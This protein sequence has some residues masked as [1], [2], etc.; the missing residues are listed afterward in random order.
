MVW[1]A[2]PPAERIQ[3]RRR[4][5][6]GATAWGSQYAVKQQQQQQQQIQID[7]S[8]WIRDFD[9]LDRARGSKSPG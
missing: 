2:M 6:C 1:N 4:F 5:E 7:S 8:E 3:S 9:Q